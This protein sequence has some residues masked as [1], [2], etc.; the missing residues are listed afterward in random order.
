MVEGQREMSESPRRVRFMV[1]VMVRGFFGFYCRFLPAKMPSRFLLPI[2]SIS[3]TMTMH[4]HGLR[5]T[6]QS[7]LGRR[8]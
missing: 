3:M 2:S 5:T 8:Q 7:I 6:Y 1:M 4:D